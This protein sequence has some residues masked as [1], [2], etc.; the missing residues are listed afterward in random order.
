MTILY[1]LRALVRW[2][3]RR[4]EIER[5]LDTDLADYID[6]SAAEKMCAGAGG[7]YNMS[8]QTCDAP[9]QNARKAGGICAA[10]AG[11]YDPVLQVCEF[12]GTK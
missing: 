3:F 2:L 1:R 10:H 5:A 4:D 12:E 7:K 9:A 8:T 6:R 11:V